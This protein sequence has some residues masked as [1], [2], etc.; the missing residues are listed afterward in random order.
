[1]NKKTGSEVT[2]VDRLRNRYRVVEWDSCGNEHIVAL[3]DDNLVGTANTTT[4]R[5]GL[6][7]VHCS[8][9]DEGNEH[10]HSAVS[11][12]GFDSAEEAIEAGADWINSNME[13]GGF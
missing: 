8:I 5:D 4:R 9:Q 10:L 7:D 11:I 3:T 13:A 1:M 2:G 6:F 12:E